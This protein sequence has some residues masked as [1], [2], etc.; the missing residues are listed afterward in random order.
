MG[1]GT[2]LISRPAERGIQPFVRPPVAQISPG[3]GPRLISGIADRGSAQEQK[4]GDATKPGL[5]RRFELGSQFIMNS[6][7]ENLG[8]EKRQN[9]PSKLPPLG[10]SPGV[11]KIDARVQAP[12]NLRLSGTS[13]ASKAVA[14][15][16][17]D[18][19]QTNLLENE[20]YGRST[21]APSNDSSHHRDDLT[22]S[23]SSDSLLWNF[24]KEASIIAD[25]D[26]HPPVSASIAA[27]NKYYENER[28]LSTQIAS[29]TKDTSGT[30]RNMATNASTN[31]TS[32][33]SANLGRD[34]SLEYL[35]R[36]LPVPPTASS[37]NDTASI[38]GGEPARQIRRAVEPFSKSEVSSDKS[39]IAGDIEAQ[40]DSVI[41][42]TS[43]RLREIQQDCGN[44]SLEHYSKKKG[45]GQIEV[46][47]G[48]VTS[49]GPGK[50]SPQEMDCN[51]P[52]FVAALERDSH[53]LA[54]A[55]CRS[56]SCF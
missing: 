56:V 51:V 19:G 30:V 9:I 18:V 13:D 23:N 1:Q 45:Y 49:E 12:T 6:Q 36:R 33:V 2:R 5:R 42:G 43:K 46:G 34:T 55:L 21:S 37:M 26:N 15:S 25:G 35:S 22:T 44:G 11:A 16:Y 41:S 4:R 7:Q 14:T 54:S 24:Q 10:R 48:V 3:Q 28:V 32:I 17:K 53:S 29:R 31:K 40:I 47:S 50:K 52:A 27:K 8:V 20:V 39:R 38:R